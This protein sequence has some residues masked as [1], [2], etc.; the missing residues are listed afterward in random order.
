MNNVPISPLSL[1]VV[2]A[3]LFASLTQFQKQAAA[4]VA[5]IA[6]IGGTFTVGWNAN[7]L[8]Q[9]TV[10]VPAKLEEIEA[11]MERGFGRIESRFAGTSDSLAVLDRRVDITQSAICDSESLVIMGTPRAID[12]ARMEEAGFAD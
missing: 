8:F 5:I 11:T 10:D 2:M 12:C 3:G 7:K 4:I 1:L 6:F 9:D